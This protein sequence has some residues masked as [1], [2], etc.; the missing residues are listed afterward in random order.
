MEKDKEIKETGEAKEEKATNKTIMERV[1]NLLSVK[2]MVTLGLT[3]C[4]AGL[5]FGSVEPS[6]EVLTLFCT[7][8]G[9]VITYFFTRKDGGK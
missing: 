9:A 5:L 1:S 3:A 8:Y 7:S 4:M 6:K 2:S